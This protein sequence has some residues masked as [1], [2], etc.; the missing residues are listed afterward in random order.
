[1][2]A[3]GGCCDGALRHRGFRSGGAAWDAPI[4][5]DAP[6]H[7]TGFA[8]FGGVYALARLSTSQCTTLNNTNQVL[9]F[10]SQSPS[11]AP[12]T[13]RL[14]SYG[15]GIH[16]SDTVG[17]RAVVCPSTAQC[18]AVDSSGRS[19]RLIR[20]R[21]VPSPPSRLTTATSWTW[22]ARRRRSAAPLCS[23]LSDCLAVDEAGRVIEG[24]PR[25]P[26]PWVFELIARAGRLTGVACASPAQ[27][28][29]VSRLGQGFLGTPSSVAI[30][31]AAQTTASPVRSR[32]IFTA[33][34][35]P[36]PAGGTV[37]FLRDGRAIRGCVAL[38]VRVSVPRARCRVR[39][40][41][42]GTDSIPAT[43]SDMAGRLSS[44]SRPVKHTVRPQ[45]ASAIQRHSGPHSEPAG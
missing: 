39:F 22:H 37:T 29:V 19:S 40:V 32:V 2:P 9:T 15:N 27:C 43:Y 6:P 44:Q 45:I 38:S 18:T 20:S 11:A 41:T 21:P 23:A 12:T 10:D 16:G 8:S 4:T 34:M 17:L 30:R 7:A 3:A 42:L 33:A 35:T 13:A 26:R 28:A 36:R 1:M 25:G 31:L 24:D 14:D 5:I